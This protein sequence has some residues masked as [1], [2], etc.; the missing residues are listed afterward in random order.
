MKI[1]LQK[2]SETEFKVIEEDKKKVKKYKLNQLIP[3]ELKKPV[4]PRSRQQLNLYWVLIGKVVDNTEF[5]HKD[6]VDEY[7]KLKM[8]FCDVYFDANG[9]STIKTKSIALDNMEQFVFDG[10]FD[11]AKEIMAGLIEVSVEELL[12]SKDDI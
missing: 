8:R 4:H 6:D 10:Y 2:I 7:V 9:N 5:P 1:T 12:K 3:A 11:R